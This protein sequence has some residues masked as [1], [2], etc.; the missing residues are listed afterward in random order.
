MD[1]RIYVDTNIIIDLFDKTRPFY[2]E[3]VFIIKDIFSNPAQDAFINTD[4]LT[5]LFYILRNRLKLSLSD[6][7]EKISF[8][9]DSFVVVPIY[10]KDIDFAID[11]CKKGAFKDYEDALQYACAE[12]SECTLLITNNKKDF[13]N[14]TISTKTSKEIVLS[15][16]R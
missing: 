7:L 9:K 12:S 6:S 3:S 16:Q 4:T 14:A 11:I 5:N 10:L 8:I 15:W 1:E 2:D 13:K